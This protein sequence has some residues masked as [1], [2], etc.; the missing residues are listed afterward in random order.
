MANTMKDA[1]TAKL[2]T[3]K[4][5]GIHILVEDLPEISFTEKKPSE[6]PDE[7]EPAAHCKKKF[8]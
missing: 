1:W 5:G 2:E 8:S 6:K 4:T 7:D 3:E